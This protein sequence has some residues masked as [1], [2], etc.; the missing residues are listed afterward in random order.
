[1]ALLRRSAQF[2]APLAESLRRFARDWSEISQP[3]LV[4]HAH[5]LFHLC[6]ILLVIG[7]IAGMYVRGVV[8]RYEAGWESTFLGPDAVGVLLRVLYGPAAALSGLALPSDPAEVEALRW[9]AFG[10]AANG[11]DAAP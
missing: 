10:A 8:L 5:R 6:A 3:M 4:W 9:S 7:L 2:N 1:E 11:A